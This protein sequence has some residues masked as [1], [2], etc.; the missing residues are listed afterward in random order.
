[1]WSH[2]WDDP[3]ARR[4]LGA[5]RRAAAGSTRLLVVEI[6]LADEPGPVMPELLNLHL[7]VMGG[8]RERT[9]DDYC[10]LLDSA[11][12]QLGEV[13]LLPSGQSLLSAQP[14]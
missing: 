6:I 4:V 7:L 2:D 8:G 1:M 3:P 14:R 9:R 10:H 5:C 13:I 12:W 11:G